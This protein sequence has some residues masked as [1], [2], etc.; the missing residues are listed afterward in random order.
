LT[1]EASLAED[2]AHVKAQVAVAGVDPAVA[3]GRPD[4]KGAV[5][6][7]LDVDAT[8][9]HLSQGI[10]PDSIQARANVELAP[11]TIAGLQISGAQ[12]DADYQNSTGE[13]RTLQIAGPDLNVQA[14]G[15]LA[16][17]E[18][19]QSNLKLH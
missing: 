8:V 14:S 3:S 2:T 5:G 10:T 13:I 19:G 12:L 17:T 6:G 9:A 16:L 1:F 7:R 4:I 11:S 18:T 15:T